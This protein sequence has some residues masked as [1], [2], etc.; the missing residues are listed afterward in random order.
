MCQFFNILPVF[1]DVDIVLICNA[2]PSTIHKI[3]IGLIHM[4]TQQRAGTPL[5]ILLLER[6][7][8]TPG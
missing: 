3:M 2:R 8:E 6:H 1:N 4:N 7:L 5:V